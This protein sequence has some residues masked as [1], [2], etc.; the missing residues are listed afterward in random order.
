MDGGCGFLRDGRLRADPS[1]RPRS[2]GPSGD[3]GSPSGISTPR[4]IVSGQVTTVTPSRQVTGPPDP[5]E[6]YRGIIC[7]SSHLPVKLLLGPDN[8]QDLPVFLFPHESGSIGP[9]PTF[10]GCS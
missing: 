4:V 2:T 6:G 10:S 8:I 9:Y 1:R 7:P 3:V 5:Q